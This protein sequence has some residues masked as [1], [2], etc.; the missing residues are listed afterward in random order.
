[1]VAPEPSPSLDSVVIEP[2]RLS[3]LSDSSCICGGWMTSDCSLGEG[4]RSVSGA[5]CAVRNVGR[6]GGAAIRGSW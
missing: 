3:Q 1:M 2:G 5:V 4:G 6:L